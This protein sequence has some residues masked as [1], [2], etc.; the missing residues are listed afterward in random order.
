MG[1]FKLTPKFELTTLPTLVIEVY[2][3]WSPSV[4]NMASKGMPMYVL[5]CFERLG[6]ALLLLLTSGLTSGPS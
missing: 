1:L 3:E 5:I 6:P 2:V 4:M